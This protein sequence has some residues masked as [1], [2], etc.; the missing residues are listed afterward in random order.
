MQCY[1]VTIC[2]D[3]LGNSVQL[4]SFLCDRYAQGCNPLNTTKY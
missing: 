2:V 1:F 4:H 3:E